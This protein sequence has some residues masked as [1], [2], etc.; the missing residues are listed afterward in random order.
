MVHV[1]MRIMFDLSTS[2]L[3]REIMIE[4][5]LSSDWLVGISGFKIKYLLIQY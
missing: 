3:T 1:E 4:K 2:L 5:R